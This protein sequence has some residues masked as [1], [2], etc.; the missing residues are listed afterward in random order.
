MKF[1]ETQH[2]PGS[3]WS[4]W[5]NYR[6]SEGGGVHLGVYRVMYGFRVRA[7]YTGDLM[8]CTLDWCGGANWKDV[9][10]LY[11][12]CLAILSQKEE[13]G[14]KWRNAEVFRG[15]PPHS[16][17]K[18][19]Y[20]DPD[21]VQKVCELAGSDFELLTLEKPSIADRLQRVAEGSE[22]DEFSLLMEAVKGR[23][24]EDR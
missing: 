15:I 5:M 22:K 23:T 24:D 16:N 8:G 1:L 3:V 10:R 14:E 18:P 9:E 4:D 21:F 12:L 19:F 17:V 6:R 13:P 2:D 20:N 7:G 11:S